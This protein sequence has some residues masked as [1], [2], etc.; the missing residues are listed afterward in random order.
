MGEPPFRACTTDIRDK[1]TRRIA[2]GLGRRTMVGRT[3]CTGAGC[4]SS[5]GGPL[6][7]EA[8]RSNR[9]VGG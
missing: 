4:H 1:M 9:Q 6:V 5:S 7:N 2:V 8:E 3:G